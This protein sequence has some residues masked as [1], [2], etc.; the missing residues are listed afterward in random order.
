MVEKITYRAIVKE[1]EVPE[2]KDYEKT[3]LIN[4]YKCGYESKFEDGYLYLGK[5]EKYPNGIYLDNFK[6][7]D[8]KLTRVDFKKILNEIIKIMEREKVS[9][10]YFHPKNRK[11]L[12]LL[13]R[14][15][16]EIVRHTDINPI[17]N[18]ILRRTLR[19]IDIKELK[20]LNQIQART[21]S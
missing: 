18:L 12:F 15:G 16:A 11:I 8:K 2:S 5:S 21:D 19:S 14:L 20:E 1:K 3:F 7:Y 4:I 10:L 17:R 9:T 6:S 13:Q